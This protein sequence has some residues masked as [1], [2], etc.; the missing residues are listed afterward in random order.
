MS[1]AKRSPLDLI[2]TARR[3]SSRVYGGLTPKLEA[4][5]PAELIGSELR[6]SMAIGTV[7]VKERT[8]EL[9]F[10]SEIELE[11]WPGLIEVL[12]HET[13]AVDLTRLNNSAPLL[14]NHDLDQPI[15]V[16]ES[17][18]IGADRKGRAVVRFGLTDEAKAALTNVQDGILKNVS[19]GYRILAV[20]KTATRESGAEVWTVTRWQPYEVSIVTVPADTTVGVG[21]SLESKPRIPQKSQI[22]TRAQLIALLTKRGITVSDTTSD[23]ELV[24]LVES[25]ETKIDVVGERAAAQTAERDRVRSIL[26]AGEQ[27]KE[28]ELARGFAESGKSVEEF[29]AELL[30][31]VDSRNRAIADA[32]KPVGL[33]E[34]ESKS[35]SFIRLMRAMCAEVGEQGKLREEAKFE[36]EACE[37]AGQRMHRPTQ[38]MVIPIDVM[39]QRAGANTTSIVSGGGYSG[40]GSNTVA[41]DLL[42]GSFIDILRNKTVLMQLASQLAGLV[43]NVDIPKQTDTTA[44]TWVGEDTAA[45]KSALNFGLVS[46]RPKT[47]TTFGQV[48][49]RMLKQNSVGVEALFRNDLAMTIAR[50]IDAAGFYG[51]GSANDPTGIKNIGG[52]HSTTFA[53]AGK[54]TFAELVAQETAIAQLNADVASMA[55]VV[56]PSTRGYAKTTRKITTSTSDATIWEP[57][58]TLN[59][60]R[61]EVTN[62]I[63]AGDVFFANFADF[64]IGLWGGL[65]VTV[66]PYSI[67]TQGGIKVVLFQDVDMAVRRAA[68]FAY[69]A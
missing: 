2:G 10:S 66:D 31:K 47:I 22:M 63:T 34:M 53:T 6:R 23:E 17:A 3:R 12:S 57:G 16:V 51:T 19:V 20:E 15:G 32:T 29:R 48:T 52:I 50:G 49:R 42:A 60:Y 21:R 43:G 14:F 65:E 56:N 18:S 69:G 36:L 38:G 64:I 24:R 59:G 4:L 35:F 13:S 26:S 25:G 28:P 68:S 61:T 40:T 46:L 33:S 54:P 5:S 30:K 58:G 1:A 39:M 7:D 9:S 8:I 55:Y 37:A 62:Q 45:T 11:L 44:A 67:S 41:T 27:Y